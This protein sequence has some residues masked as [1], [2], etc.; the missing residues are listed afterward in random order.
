MSTFRHHASSETAESRSGCVRLIL[1]ALLPVGLLLVWRSRDDAPRR[2]IL[3]T[4]QEVVGDFQI[5]SIEE[6]WASGDVVGAMSV[7]IEKNPSWLRRLLEEKGV[8]P[9]MKLRYGSDTGWAH[10]L[11]KAVRQ[12]NQETFEILLN[13]GS[14]PN[15]H[16]STG[17]TALHAAARKGFS[18]PIEQLLDAG[19]DPNQA[20][21]GGG[22]PIESAARYGHREEVELLIEASADLRFALHA[23]ADGGH[24]E[25]IQMLLDY[26]ADPLLRTEYDDS[27]LR[28]A[29]KDAYLPATE[30]LLNA[31]ARPCEQSLRSAAQG[32]HNETLRTYAKAGHR[33]DVPPTYWDALYSAS[34]AGQIETVRLL[35]ELGASP[36]PGEG[37]GAPVDAALEQGH[38]EVVAVLVAAGAKPLG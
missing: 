36:H 6:I 11:E 2:A 34:H 24:V 14:D 12:G 9:N 19:A 7:A 28:G 26:G 32:G 30:L 35:L 33:F 17:E 25:L 16:G 38:P 23:A 15:G 31:G 22:T 13:A 27:V 4:G 29:A 3:D 10:P 8:D 37:L 5:L 18:T 20:R 1:L 21:E